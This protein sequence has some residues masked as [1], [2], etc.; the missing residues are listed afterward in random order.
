[1]RSH[2][3]GLTLLCVLLARGA[4]SQAIPGLPAPIN[5]CLASNLILGRYSLHSGVRPTWLR[6]E[7]DGDGTKDYALFMVGRRSGRRAIA[8]CRTGHRVADIIGEGGLNLEEFDL[9]EVTA[10]KVELAAGW[11]ILDLK[12]PRADVLAISAKGKWCNGSP[13][14]YRKG[15]TYDFWSEATDCYGERY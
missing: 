10:W 3:I 9:A 2:I 1:M 7:F 12:P 8:I 14:L 5:E 11:E 4:V 13:I 6:G 15:N